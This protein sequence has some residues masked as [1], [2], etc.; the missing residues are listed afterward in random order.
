MR[1]NSDEARARSCADP[2]E[3]I[4][5]EFEVDVSPQIELK[6]EQAPPAKKRK[7]IVPSKKRVTKFHTAS[8]GENNC[9][10]ISCDYLDHSRYLLNPDQ[11]FGSVYRGI[12]RTVCEDSK[13][14]CPETNNGKEISIF[15][16]VSMKCSQLSS[17][18]DFD[19]IGTQF[20]SKLLNSFGMGND[21]ISLS[22]VRFMLGCRHVL[23]PQF[24]HDLLQHGLSL[25]GEAHGKDEIEQQ[26]QQ[27]CNMTSM[28]DIF[29]SY[30]DCL[31]NTFGPAFSPMWS[32][33]YEV[34][35][36]ILAELMQC[37]FLRYQPLSSFFPPFGSRDR[38]KSNDDEDRRSLVP[39]ACSKLPYLLNLLRFAARYVRNSKQFSA[40]AEVSIKTPVPCPND[41][42]LGESFLF[43]KMRCASHCPKHC[44]F[45]RNGYV[46]L[47]P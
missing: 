15:S 7:A 32:P 2:Q 33:S 3:D 47:S 18:L 19:C 20:T 43:E 34:V 10:E 38:A 11:K 4:L 12:L 40:Q 44:R 41:L 17:R 1:W 5:E 42:D 25:V 36:N 30:D 22:E 6:S 13:I 31:S 23:P 26:Q 29:M 14:E 21:L 16:P 9:S 8:P 46:Y 37:S 35:D 39:L 24:V 27:R 45:Q 28:L